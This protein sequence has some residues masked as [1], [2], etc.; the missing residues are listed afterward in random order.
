M[1]GLSPGP[2]TMKVKAWDVANNSTE[3]QIDF[4]V[5]DPKSK[6]QI[7]SLSAYPNPF[8]NQINISLIHNASTSQTSEIRYS[9]SNSLGQTLLQK[10]SILSPAPVVNLTLDFNELKTVPGVYY[11][12]VE[13]LNSGRKIDSRGLKLLRIP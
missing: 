6:A 4:M 13:I 1:T 11:L 10:S 8:S 12:L 7:L 3:D 5:I 2:H 9:I